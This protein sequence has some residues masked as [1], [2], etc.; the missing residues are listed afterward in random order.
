[1]TKGASVMVAAVMATVL[2]VILQL[3]L[4]LT[5]WLN[6]MT[7]HRWT[8]FAVTCWIALLNG[9]Y[10][11]VLYGNHKKAH[12]NRQGPSQSER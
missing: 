3:I 6:G 7:L 10:L 8:A 9:S 12:G 11:L 4:L 5:S 1:M 2:V